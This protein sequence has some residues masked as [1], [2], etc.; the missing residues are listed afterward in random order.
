[1]TI[2]LD[3]NV[4][5]TAPLK[6]HSYPA[7]LLNAIL[8]EE[9][10]LLFDNR[11]FAEYRRVL[12]RPRFGFSEEMIEPLLEYLTSAGEF[13]AADYSGRHFE[14]AE[15]K[16]FY[17]VAVTGNAD[18]LVTGNVRHFPEDPLIINPRDFA[19]RELSR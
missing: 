10:T 9:V 3:T 12:G 5:V 6:P 11:I 8:N 17:E 1:M 15:D 14:D 18:Y 4:L 13:V 2:V 16:K 19:E 7:Y